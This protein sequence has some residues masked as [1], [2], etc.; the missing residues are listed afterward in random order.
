MF[1]CIMQ[2][3][4]PWIVEYNKCML[5]RHLQYVSDK[6]RLATVNLRCIR[7]YSSSSAGVVRTTFDMQ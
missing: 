4:T 1:L 6:V 7:L 3:Y 5:T 2:E